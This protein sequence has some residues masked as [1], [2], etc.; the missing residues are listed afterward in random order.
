MISNKRDNRL[1][2]FL[3]QPHQPF[4]LLGIISAILFMVMFLLAYR[5]IINTN[6]TLLHSY[7]MIFI[8]FTN[9]FYG[10]TLTTFTRFSSQMAIDKRRYTTLFIINLVAFISMVGSIW[11]NYLFFATAIAMAISLSYLIRIF[12]QIYNKAPEPKD[13]QYMIIFS[14][15]MGALSNI[16]FI[17]SQIPCS[18]CKVDIFL[19]Y[20]IEIGIYLYMFLLATVIAFKMVPFFSR[21]MTYKKSSYFHLALVVLLTAHVVMAVSFSK[22]VWLADLF[23]ALMITYEA[24]KMDLPFPNPD[25]LLWGLHIS[26]FWIGFGF[27]ISSAVEF[28]EAYYNYYSLFMPIHILMLGFLTSILIA[29][30]TRVTLGHGGV[31]LNVNIKAMKA[32]LIFVQIVV[33]LRMVLSLL[34]SSGKIFPLFDISITAWIVMFLWW[35]YLYGKILIA[36]AR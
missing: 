1:E 23:L 34:A 24:M 4:F 31:M 3:S 14:F 33:I 15:G 6:P 10:F 36:G 22:W 19:Q 18:K 32:L 16:L 8:I 27:L 26:I 12:Y 21:V 2:Y 28:F 5:G 25:T 30:M 13:D 7:S 35:S 9:F 29:F 17:L 20:G 11:I